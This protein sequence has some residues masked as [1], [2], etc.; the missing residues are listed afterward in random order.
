MNQPNPF[1]S[2][3]QAAELLGVSPATIY[4]LI[5]LGRIPA[6]KVGS[7]LRLRT[8]A[9]LETLEKGP[10]RRDRRRRLRAVR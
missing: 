8:T 4:D 6:F 7:K 1:L 3:K 2:P 5:S 9:L 10:L